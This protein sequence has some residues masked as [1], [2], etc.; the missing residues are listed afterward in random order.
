MRTL[1][2]AYINRLKVR[3]EGKSRK[4]IIKILSDG[5]ESDTCNEFESREVT[6]YM[7]LRPNT[8]YNL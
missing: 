7:I 3:G 8:K 1:F 6:F 5:I 2:S 4:L